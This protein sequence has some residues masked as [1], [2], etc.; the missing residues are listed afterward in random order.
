MRDPE[1]Q[2]DDPFTLSGLPTRTDIF[3]LPLSGERKARTL[4]A[5]PGAETLGRISPNGRWIA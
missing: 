2:N 3:L 4:I 1:R 5:T